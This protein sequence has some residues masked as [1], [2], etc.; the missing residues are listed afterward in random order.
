M[1]SIDGNAKETRKD[2]EEG[3]EDENKIGERGREAVARIC[4]RQSDGRRYEAKKR[5]AIKIEQ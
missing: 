3:K 2:V 5:E 1:K 4:K